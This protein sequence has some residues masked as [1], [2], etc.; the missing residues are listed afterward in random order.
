MFDFVNAAFHFVAVGAVV[1]ECTLHNNC[2]AIDCQVD[3]MDGNAEDFDAE[4]EGIVDTVRPFKRG[5][6]SRV[7]I[8]DAASERLEKRRGRLSAYTRQ[9][10]PD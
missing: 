2:T 1:F 10:R 7:Y 9:G 5:E 8:E 3:K 4:V 6:Q